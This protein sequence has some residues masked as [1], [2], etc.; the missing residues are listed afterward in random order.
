MTEKEY[1]VQK[2]NR[3]MKLSQHH[4]LNWDIW[5][6][7]HL[8]AIIDRDLALIEKCIANKKAIERLNQQ[9]LNK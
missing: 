8:N 1:N 3:I 5:D 9:Q 7:H 6:R 4:Q 2:T